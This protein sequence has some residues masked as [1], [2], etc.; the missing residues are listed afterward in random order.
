VTEQY[1]FSLLGLAIRHYYTGNA[2]AA[3]ELLGKAQSYPENL[4][5]GKLYGAQENDLFYWLGCAYQSLNDPDAAE[6]YFRKAS[7]GLGDPKAAVFYND[8]K[9]DK[10]LYQGLAL[11]KLGDKAKASAVF[12]K[13]IDF[14]YEH[15]NDEIKVDYFAVSLPDLLTFDDDLNL[16]NRL[17][18]LYLLGLGQLGVQNFGEANRLFEEVL[19]IDPAHIGCK[20]HQLLTQTLIQES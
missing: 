18:N 15:M 5:E 2:E 14:G 19:A 12:N 6:K 8:Q 11:N 17:H 20:A 4:G 1:V 3:I 13:L 7:I 16:R 10:M 9:P